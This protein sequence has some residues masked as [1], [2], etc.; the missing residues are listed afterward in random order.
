VSPRRAAAEHIIRQTHVGSIVSVAL[1]RDGEGEIFELKV[2]ETC[3]VK[4]RNL[5][6]L[7]FPEGALI[8]TMVRG[9]RVW[10]PTGDDSLEA[11]DTLMVF[12]RRESRGAVEDLFRDRA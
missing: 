9:D 10:I 12:A 5:R 8:G 1:I 4:G 3:L 11:G 7:D 2:P 6:Y